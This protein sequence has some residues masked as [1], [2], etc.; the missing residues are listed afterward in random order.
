MSGGGVSPGL[1]SS[2]ERALSRAVDGPRPDD[3]AF[4]RGGVLRRMGASEINLIHRSR[5]RRNGGNLPAIGQISNNWWDMRRWKGPELSPKC[6]FSSING[7]FWQ[8]PLGR[9]PPETTRWLA[10]G[11]WVSSVC[12]HRESRTKGSSILCEGANSE[13]D[14]LNDVG[15]AAGLICPSSGL[16]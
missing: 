4:P 7:L 11:C 6:R 1:S 14:N 15:A 8:I 5:S 2:P 12:F 16:L 10:T 3:R 9:L 13:C